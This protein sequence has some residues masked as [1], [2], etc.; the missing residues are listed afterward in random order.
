VGRGRYR[1]TW[2]CVAGRSQ[3]GSV[4]AGSGGADR[5]PR[6]ALAVTRDLAA[7]VGEHGVASGAAGDAVD[8]PAV[9]GLAVAGVDAIVAGTA[10]QAVLEYESGAGSTML[11]LTGFGTSCASRVGL[12]FAELM[13]GISTDSA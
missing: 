4:R 11:P 13:C 3:A 10:G 12:P 5:A 6:D 9:G 1:A 8:L 7:R 2:R